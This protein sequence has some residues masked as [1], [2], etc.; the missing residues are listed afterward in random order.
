MASTNNTTRRPQDTLV[1][2]PVQMN[3]VNRV[4]E[5]TELAG[6]FRFNGGLLLQ[7]ALHGSGD[8]VGK[9]VIWHDAQLIGHF[10]IFGDLY[11]FGRLGARGDEVDEST[12]VECQGT[13]Y[14]AST[15]VSTGTLTAVRLRMYDGAVLQGPFKT[16]RS[17]RS[18]PV[19]GA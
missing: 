4:A 14:M 8:I 15:A 7:G 2:D 17:E 16:L 10:R 13:A 9:L 11:V 18:V 19:L 12:H 3:I 5:G 1:I 6:E